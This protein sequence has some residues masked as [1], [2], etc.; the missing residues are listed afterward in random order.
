MNRIVAWVCCLLAASPVT[1]QDN[2]WL[3]K[4]TSYIWL[5]NTDV[6][7]STPRGSV[8]GA[9]RASDALDAFDFALM[10]KFE[11]RRDRLSFAAD[12]FYL[13]V[14]ADADKPFGGLFDTASVGTKNTAFTVIAAYCVHQ[15]DRFNLDVGAGARASWTDIDVTFSGDILPTE[16]TIRTDK[17]VDP[18]IVM[19]GKY[20]FD[21]KWFGTFD[22]G[23]GCFGDSSELTHQAGLG[24]G[25]NLNASWSLSGGLRFLDLEARM[26]PIGCTSGSLA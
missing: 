17:W 18:I 25:Y 3:F 5:P 26:V 4:A 10:G 16:S 12:L 8:S 9:L 2:D 23:T 24:L 13:N 1:A 22:L 19:R 20:D 6:G 15:T 11:A 7:V 14:S 21:E